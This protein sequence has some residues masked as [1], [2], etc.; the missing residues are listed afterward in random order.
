MTKKRQ[1]R[2]TKIVLA[3]LL[4]ASLSV[5]SFASAAEVVTTNTEV[6]AEATKA[7]KTAAVI[8]FQIFKPGTTE[9]QPAIS[10]HLVPQGSIVEKDGKFEANLTITA[11]SAPMI[12]GLQTKQGD[13]FVDATE[14]KNSDGTITYSFPVVVDEVKSAKIHVVV[15]SAN[16]DKWYDFDLK[17]VKEVKEEVKVDE[18]AVTVYKNGTTEESMMKQYIAPKVGVSTKDGKNIVTMTFPQGQYVQGFTVEGKEATLVKQDD[19]TNARTYSFEVADLKKLVNAQ[20]HIVVNEP[21]QGVKYDSNHTVQFSFAVE[22]AVK[23]VINP[24]KDI[25]KDANKE[26]ILSLYSLGIVKGQD[27]FNPNNN[28]T[29][30]QFAL[31]VARALNVSSTKDAGFKDTGKLSAEAVQAINA[32][33]EAGIVKKATNFNPNDTLTRQQAAVMIYR[34]VTHVAGKEM[35]FGDPSL[36]YYA[37]GAKV[38]DEEAKKAF[39]LLYAGKVMTGSPTADGK[40]VIDANSPLK[41]SHMAKILNG[42][43]Q[44]INK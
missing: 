28:I 4:A 27:N 33:A 9:A 11:K 13:K 34:T 37:D 1:S 36:S 6:K 26:A 8:N 40:T 21:A 7:D 32:L 31:M 42:S 30:S 29:R 35:N 19:A 5:P 38:K 12:A 43:L 23:P 10:S 25:S 17:A 41:R 18:V 39:A 44:Y 22:G 24:F 16:M 2:A 14:V 20:L 3:S 15:P